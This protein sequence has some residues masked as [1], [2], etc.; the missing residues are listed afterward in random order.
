MKLV[1]RFIAILR[2]GKR[3]YGVQIE[4]ETV[5]IRHDDLNQMVVYVDVSVQYV[6]LK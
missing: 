5:V 4:N 6:L 1:N 2:I 3:S